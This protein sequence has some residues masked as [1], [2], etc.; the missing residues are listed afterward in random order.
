M[1]AAEVALMA[2]RFRLLACNPKVRELQPGNRAEAVAE[3]DHSMLD[4]LLLSGASELD[5]LCAEIVVM[6]RRRT[7]DKEQVRTL[8]RTL[9]TERWEAIQRAVLKLHNRMTG[10]PETDEWIADLDAVEAELATTTWPDPDF[11]LMCVDGEAYAEL[12]RFRVGMVRRGLGQPHELSPA[13]ER[14]IDI[15]REALAWALQEVRDG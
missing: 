3:G 12:E 4:A 8:V 1:P 14:L 13:D 5:C 11:D 7:L 10:D 9:S 2:R 15:S 6:V